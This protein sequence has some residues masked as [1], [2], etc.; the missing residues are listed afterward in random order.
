MP[1]GTF[2]TGALTLHSDIELYVDS[3]A[4]LQGLDKAEDYLPKIKSR[5]EG[6]E[7]E[8]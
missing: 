3:G 7:R 4:T 6:I 1:V 5:F 8:C 2:L